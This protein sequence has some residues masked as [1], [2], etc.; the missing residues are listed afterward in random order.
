VRAESCTL[1]Q[2]LCSQK[3]LHSCSQP[4]GSR[5]RHSRA[6]WGCQEGHHR[7]CPHPHPAATLSRM[8]SSDMAVI[9]RLVRG[10]CGTA[11]L[12]VR[13]AEAGESL[14]V[15]CEAGFPWQSPGLASALPAVLVKGSAPSRSV[16]AASPCACPGLWELDPCGWA[17]AKGPAQAASQGSGRLSGLT[18]TRPPGE[19]QHGDSQ[20]RL[21]AG[22]VKALATCRCPS[23]PEHQ[24]GS[25]SG[26]CS[27]QGSPTWLQ[28]DGLCSCHPFPG[29]R[30]CP[31]SCRRMGLCPAGKQKC[32]RRAQH[33]LPPRH[34]A[35]AQ[36]GAGEGLL[37]CTMEGVWWWGPTLS[38]VGAELAAVPW[39]GGAWSKL[40][41][42]PALLP[43]SGCAQ[44]LPT[45]AAAY[46]AVPVGAHPA[47]VPLAACPS[48]CRWPGP[49]RRAEVTGLPEARSAAGRGAG[50]GRE[51]PRPGLRS[52]VGS[53]GV[54]GAVPGRGPHLGTGPSGTG[55]T[56]RGAV[57]GP[58]R[59]LTPSRPHGLLSRHP[60]GED[61]HPGVRA[62]R[63]RMLLRVP[64]AERGE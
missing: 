37:S 19:A 52:T 32:P 34:G 56:S 18:G 12:G 46:P 9:R 50:R 64:A 47:P 15:G 16:G 53:C 48:W 33:R 8:A 27:Q 61:R 21:A 3:Y 1:Q 20:A 6:C 35:A 36:R 38:A 42:H 45:T 13:A 4:P 2:T 24:P 62:E 60:G 44:H 55:G 29:H 31:R 26:A 25:T 63:R 23:S 22:S 54:L 10:C 57:P 40:Y 30:R 28:G 59:R 5:A 41:G 17:A 39:H 51:D 11:R 49:G 14:G 7:P 58:A 43:G